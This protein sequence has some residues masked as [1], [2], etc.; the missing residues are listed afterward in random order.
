MPKKARKQPHLQVVSAE[1]KPT[2]NDPEKL[3]LIWADYA[4]ITVGPDVI[5]HNVFQTRPP[6]EFKPGEPLESVLLARF[7]YP[8]QFFKSLVALC[9]RQYLALESAQNRKQ[10]AID[11]IRGILDAQ[12]QASAPIAEKG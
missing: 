5:L 8:P 3:A 4:M 10:E 11:W 6:L 7:A 9:V 12:E 1:R 2:V